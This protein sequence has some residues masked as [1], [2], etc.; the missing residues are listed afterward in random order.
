M[1]IN[2]ETLKRFSNFNPQEDESYKSDIVFSKDVLGK[3]NKQPLFN[4]GFTEKEGEIVGIFAGDGSQ[5]YY[6]KSGQYQVNIHFGD[7]TDYIQKVEDLFE[8]FFQNNF[9]L[10]KEYNKEKKHVKYRL[11]TVSKT[12]FNYFRNYLSYIPSHKHNTVRLLNL[13]I[14]TPFKIGL[15]RGLIDTDGCVSL[16]KGKYPRVSFTSTSLQ[17]ASQFQ[18]LLQGF[19][20]EPHIYFLTPTRGYKPTYLVQIGKRDSVDRLL[21]IIKPYKAKKLGL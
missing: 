14:P 7:V 15:L 21:S 11:R 2:Q 20:I 9:F 18:F 16:D 17:L 3:F 13:D 1:F 6:A 4:C 10:I 8:S 12:I 19:S 5:Y